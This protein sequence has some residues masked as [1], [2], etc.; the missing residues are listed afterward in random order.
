MYI[1]EDQEFK[2]FNNELS[3][4]WKKTGILYGDWYGGPNGDGTFT[5]WT[6]ITASEVC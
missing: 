6:Q 5:K 4:F 2:D 3:L 1:S